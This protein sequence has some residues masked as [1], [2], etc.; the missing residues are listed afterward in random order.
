MSLL[1]LS[2]FPCNMTREQTY[3]LNMYEFISIII[4]LFTYLFTD[5]FTCTQ[6]WHMDMLCT[7]NESTPML[8]ISRFIL[9]SVFH[10]NYTLG[11]ILEFDY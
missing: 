6:V 3:L 9:K 1:N 4:F 7:G 2:S 10:P 5:L 8:Y 11:E